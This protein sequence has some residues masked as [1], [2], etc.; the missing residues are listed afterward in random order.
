MEHFLSRA[1]IA[2]IHFLAGFYEQSVISFQTA[3]DSIFNYSQ[4]M[5]CLRFYERASRRQ[6]GK[7]L[8]YSPYLVEVLLVSWIFN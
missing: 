5:K 3:H 2:M 1:V 7:T 6:Y 4:R 8:S